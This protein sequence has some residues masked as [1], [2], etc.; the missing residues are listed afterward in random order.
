MELKKIIR[1]NSILNG[2]SNAAN[3]ERWGLPFKFKVLENIEVSKRYVDIWEKLY[4]E[5]MKEFFEERTEIYKKLSDTEKLKPF[6]QGSNKAF[7][8]YFDETIF[9]SHYMVKDEDKLNDKMD[10]L[11]EKHKK[12]FDEIKKVLEEKKKI[13][14]DFFLK[15]EIPA[16]IP[17]SVLKELKNFIKKEE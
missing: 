14:F 10:E 15:Q 2:L 3:S 17:I 12:M 6:E 7:V 1:I 9:L 5:K 16:T 8:A 13:S 4:K 11:K